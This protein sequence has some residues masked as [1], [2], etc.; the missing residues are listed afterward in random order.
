MSERNSSRQNSDLHRG[1]DSLKALAETG[2]CEDAPEANALARERLLQI[3]RKH[4]ALLARFTFDGWDRGDFEALDW[5]CRLEATGHIGAARLLD[6][7][8]FTTYSSMGIDAS[9]S[10]KALAATPEMQMLGRKFPKVAQF[11]AV[12]E[13]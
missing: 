5:I 6:R 7:V 8:F 10:Q 13:P 1:I 12:M 3:Y 11:L 2:M 4:H 9:A